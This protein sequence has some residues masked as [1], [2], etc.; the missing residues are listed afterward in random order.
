MKVAANGNPGHA[1]NKILGL[2]VTVIAATSKSMKEP[3]SAAPSGAALLTSTPSCSPAS[4]RDSAS[5]PGIERTIGDV[6]VM[7]IPLKHPGLGTRTPS[8]TG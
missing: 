1:E 2:E 7:V 4:L 3:I 8:P 5:A 6:M